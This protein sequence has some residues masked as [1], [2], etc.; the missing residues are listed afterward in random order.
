VVLYRENLEEGATDILTGRGTHARV[1]RVADGA[2]SELRHR[3]EYGEV[4]ENMVR[5]QRMMMRLQS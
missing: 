2:G 3:S 5:F 1:A 4:S